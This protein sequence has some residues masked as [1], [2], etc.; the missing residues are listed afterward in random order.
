MIQVKHLSHQYQGRPALKDVSFEVPTGEILGLLGPN[1]AGKTTILQSLTGLLVP[2]A[3]EI[4][5]QGKSLRSARSEAQAHVG[6][7]PH[8]PPLYAHLTL[9]QHLQFVCRLRHLSKSQG[10]EAIEK[11]SA[12]CDLSAFLDRYPRHLSRGLCQ[13]AGLAMALIHNPAILILDEPTTGLDPAQIYATR[14]TLR[15]LKGQHTLVLSSHVLSEVESLCDQ[16]LM[17]NQ[18]EVV[19]QG[20]P[21]ELIGAYSTQFQVR[22]RQQPQALQAVSLTQ[23]VQNLQ[24]LDCLQDLY[25]LQNASESCRLQLRVHPWDEHTTPA[26]QSP[27]IQAIFQAQWEVLSWTPMGLASLEHLFLAQTQAQEDRP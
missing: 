24:A 14:E 2:D 8:H 22:L 4:T 6:Y 15:A 27:L 25:I 7:L 1:G 9:L 23:L 26:P 13:R 10:S 3:G 18:G 20:P 16:I 5:L 17:L 11:V 19:A 12:A 21:Q